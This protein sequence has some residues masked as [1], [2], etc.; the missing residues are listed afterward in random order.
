MLSCVLDYSR[1]LGQFQTVMQN[2]T[3]GILVDKVWYRFF[4]LIVQDNNY[5]HRVA[6]EQFYQHFLQQLQ[7]CE[8]SFLG[9]LLLDILSIITRGLKKVKDVGQLYYSALT[10][11]YPSNSYQVWVPGASKGASQT[12]FIKYILLSLFDL[13]LHPLIQD[14]LMAIVPDILKIIMEQPTTGAFP[15]LT[16]ATCSNV[17]AFA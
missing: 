7:A 12:L 15:W 16:E 6:L 3:S 14:Y 13:S 9:M 2:L 17:I 10:T 8:D 4:L 11:V 1:A 5:D